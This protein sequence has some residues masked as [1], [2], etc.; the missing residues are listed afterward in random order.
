MKFNWSLILLALLV[1]SCSVEQKTIPTPRKESTL[2]S[3]VLLQSFAN[4][5]FSRPDSNDLQSLTL[6]GE[7]L[8]TATATFKVVAQDGQE[9]HCETFP[10]A[11]LIQ[12]EYKTANS[13]LR[14][15][16]LRDVVKGY[17]VG[18]PP[19]QHSFAGL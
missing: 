7:S 8:L 4:K 12:P 15:A 14:E 1:L 16:H 6:S 2:T 10:A 9:I 18:V 11:E 17:F 19:E 3:D 5:P 13:V